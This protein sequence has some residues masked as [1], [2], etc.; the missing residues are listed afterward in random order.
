VTFVRPRSTTRRVVALTDASRRELERLVDADPI[1]NAVV[2]ARIGSFRSLESI[3]LGGT[4]LGARDGGALSAAVFSGGNLIPIGG[5]EEDWDALAEAL[6]R[7]PRQCT[8]L[9]GRDD[10]VSAMWRV[11]EP[12]WG[13]ARAIREAQPLLVLGR[14]DVAGR[15]PDPRL[16][17]MRSGD[18]ERYLPA[19]AA[20]FTEEL[21]ISPLA[22]AVGASYR[23]RVHS[24][25]ANGRAFGIVDADGRVAFKADLGVLTASTCQIQG[26]WTRPDLRG[27]GIGTA[28]LAGVLL[29][30][31]RLAPTVSLY[32][33]DF[34]MPARRLYARLGMR[35]LAT[36]STVLF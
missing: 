33:N 3:M 22:G 17:A 10:A 7:H 8:S 26:V 15:S 21:G 18:L 12:V 11:L 32:V 5:A 28:G 31:L 4:L 6:L 20:M 9:V 25:L 35:Q 14:G 13:P 1:V 36:L 2:A 30:A 29:Q 27:R 34:N 19:A 23:R 16:R 24:L